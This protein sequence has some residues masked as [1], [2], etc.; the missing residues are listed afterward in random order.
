MVAYAESAKCRADHTATL[1][2]H[3]QARH[4]QRLA[5]KKKKRQETHSLDT[6]KGL[7]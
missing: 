3:P 1:G 5:L 6:F 7:L 4:I 2:R